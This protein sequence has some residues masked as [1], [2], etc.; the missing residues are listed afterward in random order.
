MTFKN[1]ILEDIN[2]VFQRREYDLL[3][4]CYQHSV[5]VS[6]GREGH[7]SLD[8]PLNPEIKKYF[9]FVSR[10]HGLFSLA[11]SK[12]GLL[13]SFYTDTST[14]GSALQRNREIFELG[15]GKEEKLND[16]DII[17]IAWDKE[18]LLRDKTIK[19]IPI[20]VRYK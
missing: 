15:S 5:P 4:L 1:L 17:W 14:N 6:I 16:G 20:K 10:Y 18:V 19:G 13:E 2:L 11:R 8:F 12:K 9:P 7:I 3:G